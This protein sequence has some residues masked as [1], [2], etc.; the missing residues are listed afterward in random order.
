M[1]YILIRVNQKSKSA[2]TQEIEARNYASLHNIPIGSLFFDKSPEKDELRERREF[3][4]FLAS[5]KNND[6]LIVS[7][8]ESIGWRVG[9]LVQIIATIFSKQCEVICV[10][11]GEN[12]NREMVA[13]TLISKLSATRKQ[14]IAVGRSKLG[15][16]QGSRSK[17]KYDEYLPQIIEFLKNS[18]NISALARELSISRTSLKDY[19]A[20]RGL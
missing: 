16:P 10:D 11:T 1:N 18:R 15:R 6:R 5:L 2:L 14:N 9:E 19:I 17:S 7:S 12:I 13:H 20:S 4:A 3:L 8:L